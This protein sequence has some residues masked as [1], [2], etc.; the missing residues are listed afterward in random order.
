MPLQEVI[1]VYLLCV[2]IGAMLGFLVACIFQS[3]KQ[4]DDSIE[5]CLQCRE[6]MCRDCQDVKVLRQDLD[7][8]RTSVYR[9]GKK[10]SRTLY[11]LW[12][13][14]NKVSRMG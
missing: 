13:G 6:Q 10:Y 14:E 12:D 11:N 2:W 4:S 1:M 5:N 8:A 3:N 7:K 9:M